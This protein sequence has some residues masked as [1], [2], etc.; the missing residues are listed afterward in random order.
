MTP[1]GAAQRERLPERPDDEGRASQEANVRASMSVAERS[2]AE[3]GIVAAAEII[4]LNLTGEAVWY[5][6]VAPN[7]ARDWGVESLDSGIR[8]GDQQKWR[9][10]S[11]RYQLRAETASG[12]TV[13]HFGLRLREGQRAVWT[14]VAG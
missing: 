4:I 9:V 14:L 5:V 8:A 13:T 10:P 1:G 6:Q 11:G 12:V 2:L 3:S 7:G